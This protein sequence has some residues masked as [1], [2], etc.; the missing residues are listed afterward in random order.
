MKQISLIDK[1]QMVLVFKDQISHFKKP[2]DVFG[3]APNPRD[4]LL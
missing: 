2:L 4:R 1:A 3:I